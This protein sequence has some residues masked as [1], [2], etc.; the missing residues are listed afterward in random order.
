MTFEER[1][2]RL[3]KCNKRLTAALTLRVAAMCVAVTV[4]AFTSLTNKLIWD[5]ACY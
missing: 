2:G 3:E 5:S 4:P 1:L